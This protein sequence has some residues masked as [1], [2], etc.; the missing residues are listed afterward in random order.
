MPG[1]ER[2]GGSLGEAEAEMEVRTG[3]P[4][5]PLGQHF[6]SRHYHGP[7]LHSAVSNG[8]ITL[9]LYSLPACTPSSRATNVCSQ[10]RQ[11]TAAIR[12][13]SPK[14]RPDKP[15]P[16]VWEPLLSHLHRVQLPAHPLVFEGN[17]LSQSCSP[18]LVDRG[19][20]RPGRE[21]TCTLQPGPTSVPGPRPG[22][23][24]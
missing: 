3:A 20:P 5:P 13:P 15:G 10:P 12:P 17:S 18:R 14:S 11:Q 7:R 2:A 22:P 23:C 24:C 4:G 21:P 9:S 1:K 6:P 8:A 16:R 19:L